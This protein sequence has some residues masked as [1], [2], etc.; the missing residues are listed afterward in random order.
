MFSSTGAMVHWVSWL[1][2][3]GILLRFSLW[4]MI[5]VEVIRLTL[6]WF[7]FPLK[8]SLSVR[9][10]VLAMR[11]L[12]TFYFIY[13]LIFYP[14]FVLHSCFIYSFFGLLYRRGWDCIAWS[15]NPCVGVSFCVDVCLCHV[16]RFVPG[17]LVMRCSGSGQSWTS[18]W[19]GRMCCLVSPQFF[20]CI[21]V[22]YM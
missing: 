20:Y 14:F 11:L 17:Q 12:N 19:D 22:P 2:F 7:Q 8:M 9:C 15:V 16:C 21:F 10:Y 6:V 1:L 5:I 3:L 13:S 18:L 4:L